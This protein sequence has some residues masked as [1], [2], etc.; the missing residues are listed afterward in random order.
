MKINEK[1]KFF[2]TAKGLTNTEIGDLYGSTSATI[3]NYF[4]GKR[5]I[6]ID[7]ILWLKNEYP[8]MDLNILFKDDEN[9]E[10]CVVKVSD[11]A[12]IKN[13]ILKEM[14]TVLKKYF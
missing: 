1:I 6:P 4:N 7:F 8:E 11:T 13:E 2:F 3:G 14:E 9:T 10:I 5:D 12:D